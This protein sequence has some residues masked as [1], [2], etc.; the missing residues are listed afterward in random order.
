MLPFNRGNFEQ[1]TADVE[2]LRNLIIELNTELTIANSKLGNKNGSGK[3][4]PRRKD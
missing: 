3:A 2:R 1:L 4:K